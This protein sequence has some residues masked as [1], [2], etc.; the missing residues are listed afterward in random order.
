M[1]RRKVRFVI[2]AASIVALG[3]VDCPVRVVAKCAPRRS[4]NGVCEGEQTE[5]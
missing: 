1:G 4:A 2:W 5:N 3:S